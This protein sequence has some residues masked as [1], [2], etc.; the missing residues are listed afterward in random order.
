MGEELSKREKGLKNRQ[1]TE[2]PP[3]PLLA[4]PQKYQAKNSNI[5]AEDLVQTYSGSLI[6]SSVSVSPYES[7]LVDSVGHVLLVSLEPCGSYISFSPSSIGFL[8]LQGDKRNEDFQF[9][10]SLHLMFGC[11]SL[12]LPL[13]VTSKSLFDDYWVRHQS[14]SI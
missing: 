3:F 7:C 14:M 2:I 5:C 13:P 4:A 10:L 6:A 1:E 11:G 12:R 9:G 8:E